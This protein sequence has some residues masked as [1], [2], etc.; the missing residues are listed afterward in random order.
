METGKVTALFS[1]TRPQPRLAEH[2]VTVERLQPFFD[3]AVFDYEI[4]PDGDIHVEDGAE[5]PLWI[6]I[7][8]E[9]KLIRFYSYW[10]TETCSIGQINDLNSKFRI[11]QFALLQDRVVANY[12]LPFRHGIDTRHII[13]QARKF[14]SICRAA[15]TEVEREGG[16]A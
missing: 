16:V 13:I 11:V 7:E 14:G 15:H 9:A 12:Y 5:A 10:P 6:S 1:E 8:N 4:D 2:E 3:G